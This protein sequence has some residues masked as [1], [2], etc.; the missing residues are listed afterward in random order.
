MKV[1]PPRRD[2]SDNNIGNNP[3][4]QGVKEA[5]VKPIGGLNLRSTPSSSGERLAVVPHN[6][7]IKVLAEENG[8][9]K[10]TYAGTTGWLASEYLTFLNSSSNNSKDSSNNNSSPPKSPAK[11]KAKVNPTGGLNL[12][13]TPSSSGEKL[14]TVPHN[15]VIEVLAEE[16]GWVKTSYEGST[17]WLSGDYLTYL[18]TEEP[19]VSGV[20][21][22]NGLNLRSTPSSSGEV[23]ETIPKNTTIKILQEQG[24]WYKVEF[25]SQTGWVAKAYVQLQEEGTKGKAEEETEQKSGDSKEETS[26]GTL[27]PE[28]NLPPY[29]EDPTVDLTINGKVYILGGEGVISTKAQS[30]IEGKTLS[31]YKE[32]NRQFPPLPP[33]LKDDNPPSRGDGP[34]IP[35]IPEP[36]SYD[37]DSEA[38]VDPFAEVPRDSLQGKVIILDPGHGGPDSGAVGYSGTYEKNYTLAI[39]LALRDILIEAGAEVIM[40]R[41]G[42]YSPAA[43][44]TELEDLKARVAKANAYPEADLFISIHN[45][46]FTNPDPEGTSVFYSSAHPKV[47][48]SMHLASSLKNALVPLLGTKDRGVKAANFYV[49]RHTTIPSALV[50]VAFISNPI[51]EQRLQNPTFQHNVAVG[52]YHGI[53]KYFN[54]PVPRP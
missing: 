26:R 25:D 22:A 37:P 31:K 40:T 21:T 7:V 33:K 28:E 5:K 11:T 27:P 53:Y 9:V 18:E 8:W 42:D 4:G 19:P 1:E 38:W 17:G 29:I 23:I 47:H 34:E 51:E 2:N 52:I 32:N 10:T 48:E 6:T 45:D 30:I 44:F 20:V 24:E 14:T 54:T 15:T 35:S 3:P 43:N 12:R 41:D 16:N 50:E 49:I 13:S 36:P 46:A 39:G